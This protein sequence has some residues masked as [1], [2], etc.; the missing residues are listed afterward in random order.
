MCSEI[1]KVMALHMQSCPPQEATLT[2]TYLR[3]NGNSGPAVALPGGYRYP[4]ASQSGVVAPDITQLPLGVFASALDPALNVFPDSEH[5]QTANNDHDVSESFH[6]GGEDEPAHHFQLRQSSSKAAN[7]MP[8]YPGLCQTCGLFY[9]RLRELLRHL[10]T[11]NAD[12]LRPR[13]LVNMAEQIIL[14]ECLICGRQF[15][16]D[17]LFRHLEKS[18]GRSVPSDQLHSA[19][20]LSHWYQ[21][22]AHR[23]LPSNS[24]KHWATAITAVMK[25]KHDQHVRSVWRNLARYWSRLGYNVALGG[26][27]L[28][29]AARVQGILPLGSGG[30]HLRQHPNVIE[31]ST[32]AGANWVAA[33]DG[34]GD[35]DFLTDAD[36]LLGLNEPGFLLVQAIH[37]SDTTLLD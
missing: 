6:H 22:H 8:A 17:A 24:P 3:E 33:G 7:P 1:Q 4:E 31:S 9:N 37:G 35:G 20:Q 28:S 25:A 15:R 29:H 36:A 34:D 26:S 32:D 19:S 30:E 21:V 10:S 5:A 27:Y 2:N 16:G 14:V 18:A 13:E 11:K 23:P 12:D